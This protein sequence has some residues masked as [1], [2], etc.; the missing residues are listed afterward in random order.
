[1]TTAAFEAAYGTLGYEPCDDS[2]VESEYEKIVIYVK[3]NNEPSHVAKQLP[4]GRWSS[5]L[6]MLIDIAHVDLECLVGD[7]YGRPS[8]FMRRRREQED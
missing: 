7:F 6:G 4:D 5:K 1:M 2:E 3:S 8:V